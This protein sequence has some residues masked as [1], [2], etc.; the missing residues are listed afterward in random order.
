MQRLA[1]DGSASVCADESATLD[2]G[3]VRKAH[4]DA[5]FILGK[6]SEGVPAVDTVRIIGQHRSEQRSC[7]SARCT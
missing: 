2:A 4:D 5:L 7:R 3:T 1:H 6:I